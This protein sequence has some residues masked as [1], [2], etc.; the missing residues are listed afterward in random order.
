MEANERGVLG[1]RV[2]A[3]YDSRFTQRDERTRKEK[4]SGLEM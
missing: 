4:V 2:V 3:K 1:G